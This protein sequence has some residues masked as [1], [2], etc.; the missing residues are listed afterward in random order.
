M[1]AAL[2]P[3]LAA[4]QRAAGDARHAGKKK[5]TIPNACAQTQRDNRTGGD[6]YVKKPENK[7]LSDQLARSNG[8]I[9][10][11]DHSIPT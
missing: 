6:A 2:L 8:V 5:C 10:P 7:T 4:A 11:P 9:C 3:A 1:V